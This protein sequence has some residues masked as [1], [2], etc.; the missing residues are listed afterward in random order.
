MRLIDLER[1]ELI[2]TKARAEGGMEE[3]DR[4]LAADSSSAGGPPLRLVS[5]QDLI[6]AIKAARFEYEKVFACFRRRPGE[7]FNN[8]DIQQLFRSCNIDIKPKTISSAFAQGLETAVLVREGH[9]SY[10]LRQKSDK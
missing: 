3:I 4:I 5:D 9:G 1:S 2:I 7:Q 10:S 8:K 6:K